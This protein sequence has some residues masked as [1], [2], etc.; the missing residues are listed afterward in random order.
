MAVLLDTGF[1]YAVI[2]RTERQHEAVIN[3]ARAVREPMLLPTPVIVE[4]AFLLL[5]DIGPLAVADFV[6]ELTTTDMILVEPEVSDYGRAAAILRQYD[7][8]HIDL[9]D[10][11]IVAIAERLNI[12]LIL[13]LDQRHFRMFRPKHCVAFKLLP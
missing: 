7:D 6:G 2:N 1:V 11:L 4:V 5:R 12:D 9:V 8:A 10:S 13:T 3:A